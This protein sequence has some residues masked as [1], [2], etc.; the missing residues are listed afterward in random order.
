MGKEFYTMNK[1]DPKKPYSF[2][3]DEQGTNLVNEQILD[4]YNSGFIDRETAIDKGED[5]LSSEG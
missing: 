1:R 2:E 5:F 3:F 4:S